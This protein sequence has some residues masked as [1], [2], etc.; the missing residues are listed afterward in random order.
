MIETIGSL[1][2]EDR[3]LVLTRIQG[4]AWTAADFLIVVYLTKCANLFRAHLG[5]SKHVVPYVV[6]GLTAPFALFL[7]VAPGGMAFFRLEAVVTAPHFLLI[8]YLL[9]ANANI[10]LEGL[11]G[12][13]RDSSVNSTHAS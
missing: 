1:L 3:Y 8:L 5:K 13:L 4:T 9:A 10:V 7:P 2:S 12:L 11:H 6:L